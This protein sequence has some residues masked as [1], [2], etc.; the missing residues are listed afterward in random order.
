[1]KHIILVSLSTK[2]L[3]NEW[4]R[5]GFMC[6]TRDKYI[7]MFVPTNLGNHY[8]SNAYL[9]FYTTDNRIIIP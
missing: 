7:N 4:A 8:N 2:E 3:R 5:L 6:R 1:M 9:S